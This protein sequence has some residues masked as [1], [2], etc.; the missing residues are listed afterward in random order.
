MAR[1]QSFTMAT[2]IHVYFCDPRSPWQGTVKLTNI[3]FVARIF[4]SQR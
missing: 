2:N 4:A 1:H 3:W